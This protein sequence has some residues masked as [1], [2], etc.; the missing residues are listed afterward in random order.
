M[1]RGARFDW[2]GFI[3]QVT[4]D[5]INTFCAK[6]SNSPDSGTGGIGLCN[7]FGI[8]GAIGYKDTDLGE[9]FP[10]IGVGSLKRFSNGPYEFWTNYEI[11]P[12]QIDVVSFINRVKFAVEPVDCRGYAI[13]LY[14]SIYVKE[15]YLH[16]DYRLENVGS[17]RIET[18]EYCHNFIRINNYN[19]GKGYSL[20][21]P[22]EIRLDRE[23]NIIKANN[24][25]IGWEK[26]PEDYFYHIIEGYTDNL[27]YQW[28]LIYRPTGIGVREI[29][30]LKVSKLALWGHSHVV[31]PEVFVDIRI[32]PGEVLEW[33][34]KYEFF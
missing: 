4:L 16:I 25:S 26:T 12:Y 31:S 10:K 5:G 1:Y 2:T 8:D 17:K 20:N 9:C 19:L 7:E 23:P 3:T 11:R 28:E 15:N 18:N 27:P 21:F 6:E 29:S 14:K 24:R 32:N 13:R 30:C 22:Y 33:T 34:R